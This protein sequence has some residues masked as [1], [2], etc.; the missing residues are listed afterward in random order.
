M[1]QVTTQQKIFVSEYIKTLDGE[2]ALKAAGYKNKNP[3]TFATELLARDS[4]INEIKSQLK[5]QIESLS[6]QKGYVIQKLL[7]I[8]EFSLQE[9]DIL[10]KDGNYTGKKKLRDSSA[11]LKALESLCKYMGLSNTK[12]EDE[13][14]RE[15]KIITISNLDDEKI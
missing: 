6:V 11:G 4:I 8:A 13:E 9:E 1:K 14:Y 10:D 15:A 12:S 3:R 7:Q 2:K 5:R